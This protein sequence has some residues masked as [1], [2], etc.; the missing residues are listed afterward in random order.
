MRSLNLIITTARQHATQDYLAR[1]RGMATHISHIRTSQQL[2]I[3]PCEMSRTS[4]I[5]CTLVLPF[6]RYFMVRGMA[7]S[8]GRLFVD[9]LGGSRRIGDTTLGFGSSLRPMYSPAAL[10]A[11]DLVCKRK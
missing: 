4:C 11:L 9:E 2:A 8:E 7:C 1:R 5:S 10:L 6:E 3:A